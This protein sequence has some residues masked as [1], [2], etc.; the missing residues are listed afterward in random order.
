MKYIQALKGFRVFPADST[1][2]IDLVVTLEDG[3]RQVPTIDIN[4]AIT[5]SECLRLIE[6]AEERSGVEIDRLT[7]WVSLWEHEDKDEYLGAKNTGFADDLN[8]WNALHDEYE[9]TKSDGLLWLTRT[10]GTDAPFAYEWIDGGFRQ[11]DYF[12]KPMGEII[13]PTDAY[14]EAGTRTMK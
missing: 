6:K 7:V 11:V 1:Q 12:H 2:E 14:K 10:H 9:F 3:T 5:P 8:P 13:N 4:R